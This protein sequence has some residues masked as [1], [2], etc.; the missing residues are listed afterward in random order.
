MKIL[1]ISRGTLESARVHLRKPVIIIGRSPTCDVV[2]RAPKVK[3]VHFVVEWMG[4]GAFNK[5]SGSW[6]ISDI[7]VLSADGAGEGV[8]FSEEPVSLCGFVF[9]CIEDSL[10]SREVIGGRISEAIMSETPAQL[11]EVLE[12]I[13]TRVDSGAIE[14]VRH[15]PLLSKRARFK[16]TRRAPKF[17]IDWPGKGGTVLSV[18]LQEMPGAEVFNRGNRIS[19]PT[20]RFDNPSVVKSYPLV[21]SDV[22]QVRWYGRDFFLRFVEKVEVPPVHHDPIGSSLLLK[23]MLIVG[24]T[25]LGLGV[26]ISNTTLQKPVEGLA[27]KRLVTVELPA[28]PTPVPVLPPTPA[29]TAPPV[30]PKRESTPEKKVQPKSKPAAKSAKVPTPPKPIMVQPKQV[31]KATQPVQ[32]KPAAPLKAVPTMTPKIKDMT[33]KIKDVTSVGFLK[34]LTDQPAKGRIKQDNNELRSLV[35]AD[36]LTAKDQAAKIIVQ[37]P[38]AAGLGEESGAASRE[39]GADLGEAGSTV[40]GAGG[41]DRGAVG[42]DMGSGTGIARDSGN[43]IG[44]AEIGGFGG[45]SF[46]AG[47]SGG[48]DVSGGLDKETVRAIIKSHAREFTT[49]YERALVTAPNLQGRIVYEWVISPPGPVASAKLKSSNISS[50]ALQDCVLRV[51]KSMQ[52]P[53]ARNGRATRV[54]YPF[55]FQPKAK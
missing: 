8:I 53:A 12:I 30:E 24:A 41:Y 32:A 16:V 9:S 18:L 51:V 21:P 52:F 40:K 39:K 38:P 22:L 2:L 5:E 33:P 20:T 36:A 48:F 10:E 23:L 50:G 54:I 3:P 46:G 49:C 44:G 11:P 26:L 17:V 55:V 19:A 35:V 15:F 28:V 1:I 34:N 31:V 25:A 42:P 43:E 47:S 4:S 14:D 13:H 29:P 27:P 6:S 7:S 45:D 37:A